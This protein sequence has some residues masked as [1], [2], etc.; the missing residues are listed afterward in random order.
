MRQR[1]M[2]L[3]SA[4]VGA[5]TAYLLDPKSGNRRRRLVADALVHYTHE[6][7][8]AAATIRRDLGNRTRGIV[9]ELQRKVRPVAADDRVLHERVRAA[10]GRVVSHPHAIAVRARNGHVTLTGPVMAAEEHRLVS[11]VQ[12]IDGVKKVQ[13]RFARQRAGS[14]PSFQAEAPRASWI[15]AFDVSQQNWPP[16][17]R[18]VAGSAGTAL[19]AL[20]LVRR[21]RIGVGLIAAGASLFVRALTNLEFRRLAGIGAGRRA[22]DVQKTITVDAPVHEVFAFWDDFANFPRF[23][24]HVR[25]VRPTRDPAIWTW[26]VSGA[27]IAA[28]IEYNAVITERVLNRVLAWKTTEDSAVGHAGLIR[29]EPVDE[30]KTRIHIR[31]SYNPPGGALAH[32]VLT[33]FGA[34]P[35]SRLD[36]DLVRMKTVLETGRH[37]RLRLRS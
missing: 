25:E 4:G 31:L 36:E 28:P 23:M 1:T 17:T 15:A 19:I 16:A 34:D 3:T 20:G 18:T 10:I 11:T 14:A 37:E 35:K 22:I 29:F 8:A 2:W 5:A 6:T 30:E 7:A 21:G 13:I 27:S 12:A 9:A 26:T 33:L 24:H 32:G